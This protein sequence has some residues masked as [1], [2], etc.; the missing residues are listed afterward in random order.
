[1]VLHRDEVWITFDPYSFLER[2]R[3]DTPP[4]ETTEVSQ[5]TGETT[6]AVDK[7][8]ELERHWGT[9]RRVKRF[10]PRLRRLLRLKP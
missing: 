3:S 4:I 1:V 10:S 7:A 8:I 6:A 9:M 5:D 2:H